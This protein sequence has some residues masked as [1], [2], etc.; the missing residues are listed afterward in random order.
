[1]HDQE[2]MYDILA[3][4]GIAFPQTATVAREFTSF[5]KHLVAGCGTTVSVMVFRTYRTRCSHADIPYWPPFGLTASVPA[6]FA[7]TLIYCIVAT[8]V[9][10]LASTFNTMTDSIARFQRDAAQRERLSALGRLSTV[11]AHEIRNPLMIIKSALREGI[12]FASS[13]LADA[14]DVVG[15]APDTAPALRAVNIAAYLPPSVNI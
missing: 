2:V 9:G 10:L 4:E 6:L 14:L 3:I 5:L 15:Q 8:G 1:M 7:A 13:A 11:V 12:P